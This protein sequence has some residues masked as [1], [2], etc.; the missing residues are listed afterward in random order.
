MIERL[1]VTNFKA[2]KSL[3]LSFRPLTVLTGPNNAGKSTVVQSL[4]LADLALRGESPVPLNGPYG[5]ALGEAADVMNVEA[6]PPEIVISLEATDLRVTIRFDVPIE[7]SLSLP[8]AEMTGEPEPRRIISIYLSAERLGPRD[9]LEVDPGMQSDGV[10]D[11]GA[12]G[13]Y[14][15]QV[16]ARLDRMQ[17]REE[18]RHPSSEDLGAAITLVRQTELWLGEIVRPV[19]V[20]AEWLPNT[21][22]ATLRFR[23][24]DSR[25]EWLRPANVGFGLSYALPVIVGALVAEPGSVLIVEN[26]EAHLHPA[27][28]SA[29]GRFL[30]R[31]A[32][33]GVQTIIET[34]SD[35]VVNGVRLAVAEERVLS[36]SDA[37]IWFISPDG[38]VEIGVHE[39]GTLSSW[40]RGFF[41]QVE[42]DLAQL[43]RI[44]RQR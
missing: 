8:V 20:Q 39:T 28:Q 32:A 35:H 7:R 17:V 21:S 11:V 42:T 30:A 38:I 41:D 31:T 40:P 5:L 44:K 24:D 1:H 10:L 9:L 37:A 36:S 2:F 18:L 6:D 26:P 12:Q 33:S 13:E 14:T 23:G 3:E 19:L 43:S 16:L 15:P 27:G 34:H 22:A 4:L 29:I 25:T